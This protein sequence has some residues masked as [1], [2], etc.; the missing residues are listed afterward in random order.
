MGEEYFVP[1]KRTLTDD[2][3]EALVEQLL[4]H[5]DVCHMGLTP[6]EVSMLKRLLSAFDRASNVIGA[7]VLTAL[8]TGMI[9]LLTKGF[10]VAVITGVK[11]GDGK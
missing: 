5:T 7:V 10:W 4:N 3:I 2:D 11:Q 1:R 8:V 9:A 6:D